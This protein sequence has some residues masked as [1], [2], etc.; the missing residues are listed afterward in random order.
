MEE[1]A[2][3]T[4]EFAERLEKR[5]DE[6]K[7]LYAELYHN[8]ENAFRYFLSMLERMYEARSEELK[9]LDRE[10]EQSAG[11]YRS[12]EVLGMMLYTNCFA[13]NLRGV[14]EKLP[15]LKESGVSSGP[16]KTSRHLPRIAIRTA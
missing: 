13:G 1:R 15:Y 14:R 11:W 5:L 8:D 16:W 7:W 3:L 2:G 4:R 6:L 9:V 12:N 10:R